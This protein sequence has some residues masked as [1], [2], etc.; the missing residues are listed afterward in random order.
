MADVAPLRMYRITLKCGCVPADE[1][2]RAASEIQREFDGRPHHVDA[3]CWWDGRSLFLTAW[4][5]FD[6]TGTA[7]RDEFSDAITAYVM[8]PFRGDI[9]I[10]E[11]L[12][13]T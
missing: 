7:L 4:N 5:D 8:T 13:M 11:V 2:L 3:H 1:G 9:A 12:S 10:I 6:E